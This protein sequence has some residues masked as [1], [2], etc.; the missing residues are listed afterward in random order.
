MGGR[1]PVRVEGEE[2]CDGED[3]RNQESHDEGH[4]DEQQEC[5]LEFHFVFKIILASV[6]WFKFAN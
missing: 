2:K 1:I 5:S 4:D 3:E 6:L